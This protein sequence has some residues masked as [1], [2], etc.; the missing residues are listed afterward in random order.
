MTISVAPRVH[1]AVLSDK[2]YMF[3]SN[4]DGQLGLGSRWKFKLK[5]V[6]LEIKGWGILFGILVLKIKHKYKFSEI[7]S[8]RH[9][10]FPFPNAYQ[11][12]TLPAK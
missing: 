11:L 4:E 7:L 5:P 10:P 6:A 1:S 12:G 3:G 2:L 8:L 9:S